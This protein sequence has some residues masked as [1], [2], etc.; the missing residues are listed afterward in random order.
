VCSRAWR[1]YPV[2]QGERQGRGTVSGKGR[3]IFL[4]SCGTGLGFLLPQLTLTATI[5]PTTNNEAK[6]PY[7]L[8]GI[9][10]I[11]IINALFSYPTSNSRAKQTWNAQFIAVCRSVK[12]A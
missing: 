2:G 1:W 8:R 4:Y 6:D 7:K 3:L 11:G 10:G 12:T 5:S 9:V